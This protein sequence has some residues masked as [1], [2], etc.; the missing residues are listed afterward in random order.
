MFPTRSASGSL[1]VAGV[2][3][4]GQSVMVGSFG[5]LLVFPTSLVTLFALGV[6]MDFGGFPS[7]A[8]MFSFSA[9]RAFS[10]SAVGAPSINWK[11]LSFVRVWVDGMMGGPGITCRVG[12]AA[13]LLLGWWGKAPLRGRFH[14]PR[15]CCRRGDECVVNGCQMSSK[16]LGLLLVLVKE[17]PLARRHGGGGWR[18][19]LKWSERVNASRAANDMGRSQSGTWKRSHVAGRANFGGVGAMSVLEPPPT[20]IGHGIDRSLLD[21]HIAGASAYHV[22]S[23]ATGTKNG[24]GGC[25]CTNCSSIAPRHRAS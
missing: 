8:G 17:R 24:P 20:A 22:H 25:F 7:A 9:S 16:Y 19:R 13:W 4:G 15:N 6:A 2:D 18:R 3:G 11:A 12:G 14:W 23:R 1:V 10:D 5:V 21:R